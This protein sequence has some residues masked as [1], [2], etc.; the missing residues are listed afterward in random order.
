M[1]IQNTCKYTMVIIS[2]TYKKKLKKS[3][4]NGR[5]KVIHLIKLNGSKVGQCLRI[6]ICYISHTN[7]HSSSKTIRSKELQ[8]TFQSQQ[9]FHL[10][11]FIEKKPVT[12]AYFFQSIRQGMLVGRYSQQSLFTLNFLPGMWYETKKS[13][14]YII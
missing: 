13:T 4:W 11:P 6:S 9:T 5:L 10:W 2:I 3:D 12:V 14:R 7:T 8:T 1:G